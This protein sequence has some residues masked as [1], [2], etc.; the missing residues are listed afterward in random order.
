MWPGSLLL[1]ACTTARTPTP[2]RPSGAV[3]DETA[4][5]T[6]PAAAPARP[7]AS[8]GPVA[9]A[10][11]SLSD[12]ELCRAD[13]FDFAYRFEET[14]DT[15]EMRCGVGP[16]TACTDERMD[17]C[18]GTKLF[19]CVDGKMGMIDCR[20]FCREVGD[21]DGVTHDGGMCKPS[22][23][24]KVCVCCDAGEPGCADEKPRPKFR[25]IVPLER[26]KPRRAG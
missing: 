4:G 12:D 6:V 24:Y 23:G 19:S 17:H 16:G 21:P 26:G 25:S 11:A 20:E 14:D 7:S 2:E 10:K 9:E 3:G 18:S 1:L 13:G 8:G 15:R 22:G 5:A